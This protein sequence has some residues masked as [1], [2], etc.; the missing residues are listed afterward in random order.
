[1]KL[2]KMLLV[3]SKYKLVDYTTICIKASVILLAGIHKNRM[4]R[5][6]L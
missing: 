5:D 1:M 3:N 2:Y 4:F 6:F